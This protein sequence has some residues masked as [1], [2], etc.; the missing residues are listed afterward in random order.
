VRTVQIEASDGLRLVADEWG[1]PSSP[2][3]LMCH[4]AGQNRYAWKSSAEILSQRGWFVTTLDARGHG[5]SD[6]SPESKYDSEDIGRDIAVVLERFDSPP[7][8]VGASMGGMASLAAQRASQRQLYKAVVL[9]DITPHFDMEG[10]SKIIDFMSGNPDGFAS[11]EDAADAISAY[12][13]HRSRP[14][15]PS[16]LARV[17]QQRPDGRWVWKWDPA[18]V[19]SK[20]GFDTGD[21]SVLA[22]HMERVSKVMTEGMLATTVPILLVRG[23]QSELV[24][25]EAVKSFLDLV[26]DAEFVDV[27]GTGHMVAGD[28][29]DAF[30]EAVAAFLARHHPVSA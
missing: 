25:P 26:P 20:P 15:N 22:T 5:D 6:W 24:T 16:G 17:L 1:D 9:V 28:D 2:S 30:T 18:Y 27:A 23:G 4:G 11:L 8:V 10:A 29:N 7:A 12:N 21:Q 13:P 19:T 14:S 3:V